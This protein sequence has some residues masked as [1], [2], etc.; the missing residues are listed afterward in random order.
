MVSRR[1]TLLFIKVCNLF[2]VHEQCS[3][4]VALGA[5]RVAQ[6]VKLS[7]FAATN[8]DILVK[9]LYFK[10]TFLTV[11]EE[12]NSHQI[13]KFHVKISMCLKVNSVIVK[14][15]RKHVYHRARVYNSGSKPDKL[16]FK[17]IHGYYVNHNFLFTKPCFALK[18]HSYTHVCLANRNLLGYMSASALQSTRPTAHQ[19]HAAQTPLIR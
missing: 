19:L 3:C 17:K 12:I 16:K 8:V 7:T 10:F 2:I 6:T 11:V 4:D 1:G 15:L 18:M 14:G 13:T 5:Y 9:N